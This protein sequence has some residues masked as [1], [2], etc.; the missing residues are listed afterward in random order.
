MRGARGFGGL[1]GQQQR[2]SSC[3]TLSSYSHVQQMMQQEH[4]NKKVKL[5]Q[6]IVK[7]QEEKLKLRKQQEAHAN[8]SYQQRAP[9]MRTN[10]GRRLMSS[11]SNQ[12]QRPVSS[13]GY[14]YTDHHQQQQHQHQQAPAATAADQHFFYTDSQQQDSNADVQQLKYKMNNLN[15][16]S[17]GH[18]ASRNTA[19]PLSSDQNKHQKRARLVL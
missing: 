6:S 10:S 2:P 18:D 17:G 4:F 1:Q 13:H 14:L 11:S 16:N 3:Y 7:L 8:N 19:E 12:Q 9:V 5:K 15:V